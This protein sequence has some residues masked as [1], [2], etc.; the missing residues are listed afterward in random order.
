[1]G[2]C[3]LSRSVVVKGNARANSSRYP[4]VTEVIHKE[5]LSVVPG[6]VESCYVLDAY[7]TQVLQRLVHLLFIG[8]IEME[9]TE[10][11]KDAVL[12]KEPFCLQKGIDNARVGASGDND[13]PFAGEFNKK[14]LIVTDPVAHQLALFFQECIGHALLKRVC[15]SISPETYTPCP[16]AVKPPLRRILDWNSLSNLFSMPQGPTT[17]AP[18]LMNRLMPHAAGW[19]TRRQD[20]FAL[21]TALARPP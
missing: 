9:A 11:G 17:L 6:T 15:R 4:F 14:G 12:W 8:I 18:N 21:L 19:S 16:S 5:L 20:F 2:I 1:M 7:P 13:K 10:Y 3:V